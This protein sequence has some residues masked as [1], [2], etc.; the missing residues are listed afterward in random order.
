MTPVCSDM[1]TYKN[2]SQ[3][4]Q[5]QEGKMLK[6]AQ[7]LFFFKQTYIS[8]EQYMKSSIKYTNNPTQVLSYLALDVIMG[9]HRGELSLSIGNISW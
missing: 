3:T 4:S 7:A 6:R 2:T 8:H 1:S 9:A 5:A